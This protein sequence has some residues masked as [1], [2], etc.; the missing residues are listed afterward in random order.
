MGLGICVMHYVGVSA[1]HLA[2][3][4]YQARAFVAA[5][6]VVSIAASGF[7]L[8]LLGATALGLAISGTHY[9]PW[10]GCGWTRSASSRAA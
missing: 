5:S 4:I 1:I 8:W 3:P 2:G 10:P 6:L 7:A 9:T